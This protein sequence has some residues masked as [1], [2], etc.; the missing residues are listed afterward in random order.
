MKYCLPTQS[1]NVACGYVHAEGGAQGGG[2]KQSRK[3]STQAEGDLLVY[4]IR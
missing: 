2:G 4:S 1:S 3:K